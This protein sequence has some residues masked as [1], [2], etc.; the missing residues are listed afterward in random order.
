MKE[1][2]AVGAAHDQDSRVRDFLADSLALWGVAGAIEA[3]AAPVVAVI[4]TGA[5]AIVSVERPAQADAEF[6]WL[7]CSRGGAYARPCSSLVGVLNGVRNALGVER[8]SA[9]HIAP[10]PAGA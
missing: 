5:G 6:R 2:P 8:G 4:R 10:A 3:G 9:V 7:V 1:D